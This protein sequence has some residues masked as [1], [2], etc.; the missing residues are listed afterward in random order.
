MTFLLQLNL[1]LEIR[2]S[3]VRSKKNSRTSSQYLGIYEA[4]WSNLHPNLP[5]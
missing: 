2:N 5:I 3:V 1:R 4:V